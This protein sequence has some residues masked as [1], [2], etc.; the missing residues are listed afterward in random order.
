MTIIYFILVLGFNLLGNIDSLKK[1][2]E[3]EENLKERVELYRKIGFE[4]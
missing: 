2:A 4:K 1:A 3:N